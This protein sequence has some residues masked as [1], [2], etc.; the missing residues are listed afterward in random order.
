MRVAELLRDYRDGEEHGW[1][2]E[3]RWIW[4]EHTQRTTALLLDALHDGIREPIL[5]GDDGRVHDGHHRLAVAVAL[6]LD[7]VPVIHV[8]EVE[9]VEYRADG[10]LAITRQKASR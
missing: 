6:M 9:S 7:E 10:S 4:F 2:T 1:A 3:F 5:L 8:D